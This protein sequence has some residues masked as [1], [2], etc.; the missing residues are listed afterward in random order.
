VGE[1]DGEEG[2]E[3]PFPGEEHTEE[4]EQGDEREADA[5]YNEEQGD[6]E[7]VADDTQAHCR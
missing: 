3:Q 7:V 6:G 4:A 1:E 2:V 5:R